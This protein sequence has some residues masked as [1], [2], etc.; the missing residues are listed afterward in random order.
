MKKLFG[1]LAVF[2]ASALMPLTAMA[3]SSNS[4]SGVTTVKQSEPLGSEYTDSTKAKVATDGEM[5]NPVY[6][7]LVPQTGI[8]PDSSIIIQSENGIFN[9][10]VYAMPI[11]ISAAGNSYDAME[12]ELNSGIN[13]ADIFK[14]NLGSKGAELP[15]KIVNVSSN[16]IEVSLFPIAEVYCDKEDNSVCYTKPYYYI[17]LH[18]IASNEGNLRVMIDENE[19]NITGGGKYTVAYVTSNTSKYTVEGGSIYYNSIGYIVDCDTTVTKAIIPDSIN[20]LKIISIKPGAFNGCTNLTEVHIPA[21]VTNIYKDTF[22]D[23]NKEN[24][25]LYVAEGSYAHNWAIQNG[26]KYTITSTVSYGDSDGNGILTASD[27]SYIVQKVLN[28]GYLTPIEQNTGAE[29]STKFDVNKD[30]I[31]SSADAAV[32]LQKSLNTS[33]I[34]ECEK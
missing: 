6:L 19:S 8:D 28:S 11:Y 12:N 7:K 15:Y 4:I 31:I 9:K 2:I 1:T 17:P 5:Y 3:A 13:Q 23:C 30:G 22:A 27:C 26:F 34:M 20:S 10:D 24:F 25:T 32:V 16:E 18:L 33:Y 14:N 21:S 29:L